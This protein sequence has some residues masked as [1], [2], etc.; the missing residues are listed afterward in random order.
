MNGIAEDMFKQIRCYMSTVKENLQDSVPKAI[1]LYVIHKLEAYIKNKLLC[2]FIGRTNAEYVS[3]FWE[4]KNQFPIFI[5][6]KKNVPFIF[7]QLKWFTLAPDVDEKYTRKIQT[8]EACK[9]ALKIIRMYLSLVF[10]AH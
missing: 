4:K 7:L 10:F 3:K 1:T 8:Y 2:D 6:V 9:A 5:N